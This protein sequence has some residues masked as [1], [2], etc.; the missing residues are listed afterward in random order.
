MTLVV[1]IPLIASFVLVD[2]AP[3]IDMLDSHP[4]ADRPKAPAGPLLNRML[5]A[6]FTKHTRVK[7]EML[8]AFLPRRDAARESGQAA[9]E[10]RFA[11]ARVADLEADPDVA[12]IAGWVADARA[13]GRIGPAVQAAIGR[14]FDEHYA[15]QDRAFSDALVLDRY[16]RASPVYA[17]ICRATG[18]LG[19]ALRRLA[20]RVADDP[21]GV[22]GT[23]IAVHNAVAAVERMRDAVHDPGVAP[24]LRDDTVAAICLRPPRAVIRVATGRI[25]LPDRRTPIR[26]GSVIVMRL[27]RAAGRSAS[28]DQVFRTNSWA[29]CP[30]RRLIA[31]LL[32]AVFRVA[33]GRAG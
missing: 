26:P 11:R 23:G 22:H 24:R 16:F 13:A 9:L 14:Q 30:A 17:L 27:G 21:A 32:V 28:L 33:S 8:P 7:G 31:N 6:R 18:R 20:N 10:A 3:T 25:Q 12:R 29:H 15:A 2:D 5:I 19:R 1:D 4:Q